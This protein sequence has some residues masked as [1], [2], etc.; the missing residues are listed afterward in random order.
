MLKCL[1]EFCSVA[2]VHNDALVVFEIYKSPHIEVPLKTFYLVQIYYTRFADADK[3]C[4]FMIINDILK[5][6]FYLKTG[7]TGVAKGLAVNSFKIK[8]G[9]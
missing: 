5:R 1:I 3:T 4:I 9:R 2:S 7:V 6:L 8:D